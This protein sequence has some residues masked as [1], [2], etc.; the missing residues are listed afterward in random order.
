MQLIIGAVFLNVPSGHIADIIPPARVYLSA[1]VT[2]S[3]LSEAAAFEGKGKESIC[4][5]NVTRSHTAAPRARVVTGSPCMACGGSTELPPGLGARLAAGQAGKGAGMG[6]GGAVAVEGAGALVSG[7]KGPLR[8]G[9]WA[10]AGLCSSPFARPR[11]WGRTWGRKPRPA[12]LAPAPLAPPSNPRPRPARP[13]GTGQRRGPGHRPGVLR[14]RG[15]RA[16][17]PGAEQGTRSQRGLPAWSPDPQAW[18]RL[19]VGVAAL[20]R[21]GSPPLALVT[22]AARVTPAPAPLTRSPLVPQFPLCK[23]RRPPG[24]A[25]GETT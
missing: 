1:R 17:Q 9:W 11:S 12:E 2:D 7:Q 21:P 3:F 25:A 6:V 10:Q 24:R 18:P 20:S 5:R 23:G 8:G 22:I 15:G 13:R 4:R 16:G 14:P 19:A